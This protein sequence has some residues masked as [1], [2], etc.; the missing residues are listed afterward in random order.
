MILVVVH[1]FKNKD[2]IELVKIISARKATKKE[3]KVYQERCL[4]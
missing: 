1:T 2:D 4:K 3:K